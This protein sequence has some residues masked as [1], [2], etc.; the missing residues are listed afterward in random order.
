MSL[1]E[2]WINLMYKIILMMYYQHPV[3]CFLSILWKHTNTTEK[4]HEQSRWTWTLIWVMLDTVDL[5]ELHLPVHL[6]LLV[7]LTTIATWAPVLENPVHIVARQATIPNPQPTLMLL[8]TTASPMAPLLILPWLAPMQ[9]LFSPESMVLAML[10]PP[11]LLELLQLL[12]PA[13]PAP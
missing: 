7:S 2:L 4:K 13:V 11:W 9:D 6:L 12:Q 3:I 5:L 10:L 8:E 1:E